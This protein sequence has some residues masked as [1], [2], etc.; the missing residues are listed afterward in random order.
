MSTLLV[1]ECDGS[2]EDPVQP[3]SDINH[4]NQSAAIFEAA[5]SLRPFGGE[6]RFMLEFNV[7]VGNGNGGRYGPTAGGGWLCL[8]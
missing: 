4:S 8:W 7:N 5:M 6:R 2:Q 3:D 1:A